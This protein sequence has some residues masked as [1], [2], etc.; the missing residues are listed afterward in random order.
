MLHAWTRFSQAVI[1][2]PM[3]EH[4]ERPWGSYTVLD[5]GVGYKVKRIE[6]LPQKRLSYQKHAQ[7]TEHWMI[8][9]G[10][11]KVTLDGAETTMSVGQTIDVPV[12]AAHR[13]ENVGTEELIFIEIQRGHYYSPDELRRSLRDSPDRVAGAHSARSRPASVPWA[14]IFCGLALIIP[15]SCRRNA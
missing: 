8:V 7:R 4:D 13:V 6:V 5:E 9:S 3:L 2:R 11:A 12:G 10:A 15:A 1:L 14:M